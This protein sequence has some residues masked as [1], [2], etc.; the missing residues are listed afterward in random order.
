MTAAQTQQLNEQLAA[1]AKDTSQIPGLRDTVDD[2]RETAATQ[3]ALAADTRKDVAVLQKD[4]YGRPG[5]GDSPGLKGNV[6]S[7]MGFRR[8]VRWGLS[9]AWAIVSA[10]MLLAASTVW[11]KLIGG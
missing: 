2:L 10:L 7:L 11:K 9:A 5:N 4:M 8:N 6:L 1:I 3:S